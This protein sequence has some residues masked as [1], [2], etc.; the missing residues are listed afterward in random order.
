MHHGHIEN[1]TD[2]LAT[3]THPLA[4]LK[5]KALHKF[6]QFFHCTG[7]YIYDH[8]LWVSASHTCARTIQYQ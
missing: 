1:R 5:A 2:S 3:A 7:G 6:R 8:P 4:D